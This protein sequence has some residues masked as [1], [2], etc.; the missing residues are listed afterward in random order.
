MHVVKGH[1]TVCGLHE[2]IL[3]IVVFNELSDWRN[4]EHRSLLKMIF[5]EV[6]ISGGARRFVLQFYYVSDGL[7]ARLESVWC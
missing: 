3:V 7:R 1:L 4:I 6:H 5:K 2:Y